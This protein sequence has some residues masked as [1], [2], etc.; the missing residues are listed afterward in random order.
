MYRDAIS[1]TSMTRLRSEPPMPSL[2]A[3]GAGS[4]SLVMTLT[5]SNSADGLHLTRRTAP[6]PS[7]RSGPAAGPR[8]G[9]GHLLPDVSFVLLVVEVKKQEEQ[10]GHE[11]DR[12]KLRAFES[13]PFRYQH[14]AFLILQTDGGLPY[15]K[16]IEPSR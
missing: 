12:E 1:G 5:V 13:G 6:V 3:T 10:R 4:P 9:T 14:A 8:A 15:W 11:D 16:W 2:N 7:S